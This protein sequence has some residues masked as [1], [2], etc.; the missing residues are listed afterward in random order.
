MWLHYKVRSLARAPHYVSEMAFGYNRPLPP[1]LSSFPT[2]FLLLS[3]FSH[4]RCAPTF[5]V[6]F[7]KEGQGREI[8]EKLCTGFARQKAH[9]RKCVL[10]S[11]SAIA[12]RWKYSERFERNRLRIFSFDIRQLIYNS[13]LETVDFTEGIFEF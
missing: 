13:Y 3:C 5:G 2:A 12:S 6:S 7:G 10:F 1:S 9:D 11:S 4:W 8:Y